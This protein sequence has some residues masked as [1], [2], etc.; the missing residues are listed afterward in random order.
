MSEYCI[1]GLLQELWPDGKVPLEKLAIQKNFGPKSFALIAVEM[2]VLGFSLIV[3][4]LNRHIKDFVKVAEEHEVEC[5]IEGDIQ[6]NSAAHRRA[7][8]A[9]LECK[10]TGE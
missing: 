4:S 7:I 6:S 1:S 2:K 5:I 10:E 3:S 9:L 8:R